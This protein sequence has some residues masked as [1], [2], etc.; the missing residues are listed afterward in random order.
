M[1]NENCPAI[2]TT[3]LS[4]GW[5]ELLI[6][7]H[8]SPG[9][10]LIPALLTINGIDSGA[11]LEQA[12]IREML[13]ANLRERGKALSSTVAGTIFPNSMWN[14]SLPRQVLFERY[15]NA[16]SQL[17]KCPQNHNGIYF[18]RMTSY[19]QND[20]N[21]LDF[22]LR[23]RL[24]KDNHRRSVLQVAIVE[25]EKDLTNQRVRG[26]PCLQQVSFAPMPKERLAVNGFYGTQYLYEKAYGN[27]LGLVHLGR[28]I[29]HELGLQ[30][31]QV[32]CFTGIATLGVAKSKIA[33][34]V[35]RLEEVVCA[36]N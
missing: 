18:E 31:A 5:A 1:T 15:E 20:Y 27:Y 36:Y 33:A 35:T 8:R 24:E 32:N 14:P 22:F 25:P 6:H 26:F 13:D 12:D 16:L 28:F 11:D 9:G 3:N 23:S 34:L 29:A 7:A 21:Q 17:R 10:Q 2:V 30:L 19:G 4:V